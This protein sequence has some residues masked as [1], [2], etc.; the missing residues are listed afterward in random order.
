MAKVGY[1]LSSLPPFFL[2]D[3][4]FFV[5]IPSLSIKPGSVHVSTGDLHTVPPGGCLQGTSGRE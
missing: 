4:C 3:A 5:P 2:L 1:V